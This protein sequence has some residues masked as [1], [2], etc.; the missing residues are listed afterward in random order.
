MDF[1]DINSNSIDPNNGYVDYTATI[2]HVVPGTG[3]T[4]TVNTDVGYDMNCAAFFD[5]DLDGTFETRVDLG[6]IASDGYCTPATALS[7]TINVP[8]N[9]ANGN[10]RMRLIQSY[11]SIVGAC[12]ASFSYGQVLDYTLAV[13]P[14][15][16]CLAP[17]GLLASN[18]TLSSATLNWTAS[19]SNPSGGYQWEVRSSGTPGSPSPAASGTA[20]GTTA[21]ASGLASSTTYRF[22]VRADCGGGD[23]SAWAT[24]PM[25]ETVWG[26]GANWTSPGGAAN[27]SDV[28]FTEAHTVCPTNP[29]DVV[30]VN[31]TTWNGLR[32]NAP[33]ASR[34]YIFDGDN[35]GAPMVP[36]GNGPAYSGT[37][38]TIP[39]GGW[40]STNNTNKPPTYTST[41]ANGCLTVQVYS[42]GIWTTLGQ[43]WS[44]DFTCAPAPT[45]FAP[46]DRTV[47]G[48]TVHDASF[49]W[50]AGASPNVEYKVVA[51]GDPATGT[52]ITNGTSSTGSAT[53]AATL[54]ANTQ[55][56]VY[57]RGLCDDQGVGDD[58]SAWSDPG[59]N[60][61]TQVGCGGPYNI[62]FRPSG[63][64]APFDSVMTIC[65][66]NAGDVVTYT[67]SQ[68]NLSNVYTY[69]AFYVYDGPNVSAPMLASNKPGLTNGANSIPAGGYYGSP[70]Q[71]TPPGPFTSTH[72][73]GC[74]TLRFR[75]VGIDTYY[76]KPVKGT[77]S[78]TA[79]PACSSPNA[80]TFSA[81]GG[82]TATVSWGNTTEPCIVEYGP[83]GFTPGT[84]AT[85]GTNGTIA[86]SNA[87]SP[88]TISGLSGT[89]TYNV[90]V[91]QVC[92]G[93]SYSANSFRT[94]VTTSMD[95]S[96]ALVITCNE[97][98]SDDDAPE[99]YAFG[100]P[101]YDGDKYTGATTC[102]SSAAEGN[103]PERLYRFTATEA[104][105]YG[106]VAGTSDMGGTSTI[107]FV[108]A[109][110]SD[111]CAAA[112][113]SCIG[114]VPAN[115]GGILTFNVPAA[116]DYYVMSDAN[117]VVH[118]QPFTLACPGVPA[119]ANAPTYPANGTTLAVNTNQIAFSWPAVFGA[120][121][122]DVYFQ[123][124]LVVANYPGTTISDAQYTTANMKAL[125]GI[126][127]PIHW[128]VV[129]TNSFGTPTCTT[130]WTF[131]VGGNG[132]ANAIP[133]S[134]GVV[135]NGSRNASA[136]FSNMETS[137]WGVD[138]WM[139]FT[140]S[141]CADSAEVNMCLP[142]N[143][144]YS[145]MAL[146][147]RRVSDN[148][149][150]FPP[151]D[152]L[153]YYQW[154]VAPGACFLYSWFNDDPEV[155]NWID[156][157]PKFPVIPGE[158]YY[159]IAD[160]YADVS[161]ITMSY[162]EISNSPDSDGDGI[163]DCMDNCPFTPGVVGSA[164][165]V[166]AGFTAAFINADCECVQGNMAV[167]NI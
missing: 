118:K 124:S 162:T 59:L 93:P 164:C 6:V 30:T 157:T 82:T 136:G 91:R 80:V 114:K 143:A 67:V 161:D 76:D 61:T 135:Y 8:N 112:A 39:A 123:G 14:P 81:V 63:N 145:S 16:T 85:V 3:Y 86:S 21:S 43:G 42:A 141:E 83:V 154:Q 18:M 52:A 58:P 55:Y 45:C 158:S 70:Y 117:Y 140:A 54:T 166:E 56:T 105:T 151:A 49:S 26:C 22:Y 134:E 34:M 74:L 50:N 146:V 68:L 69:S 90:F 109:P 95:C 2:G 41:A 132:G 131:R 37:E 138:F 153:S 33:N 5:W 150:V 73:S 152:D 17:T 24:S 78:C 66:E 75:A 148:A 51:G 77:V 100:T 127:T 101:A 122:Y 89:T 115:A 102:F 62:F 125:F 47:T 84:G 28:Q 97:Y 139:K 65:P 163:P 130:D 46:T 1:A 23:Y 15:P 144:Q 111:G 88:F 96:T 44:A 35:T 29:G 60:F 106:I 99:A 92:S 133:M 20:M 36:G 121:G 4:L 149:V 104:G 94:S 72:A 156:E 11:F 38:W 137:F 13:G 40:T 142:A 19:T 10:T 113:F 128:S 107:K 12:E 64:V 165:D 167:V 116:G 9:A 48:T 71:T 7:G 120:T 25:F 79:A 129:P 27:L 31:F 159:V 108:M 53:T 57:F 155:W 110:V 160:G 126:G 147:V 87:T 119:C 103:G 98:V 32:W